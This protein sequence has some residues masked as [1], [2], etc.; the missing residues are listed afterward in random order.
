MTPE[1]PL[2]LIDTWK[3]RVMAAVRVRDPGDADRIAERCAEAE[4]SGNRYTSVWHE[5]AGFYGTKC[6]CHRCAN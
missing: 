4:W 1:I 6:H 2:S 3:S 5:A